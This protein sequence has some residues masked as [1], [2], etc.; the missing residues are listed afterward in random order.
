MTAPAPQPSIADVDAA[1]RSVLRS[2]LAPARG[3]LADGARFAPARDDMFTG[4]LLS[5]REAEAL[6]PGA[7]VVRVAPGT[8]V[9]PLARDH[10]KRQGVEVRFVSRAEVDRARNAGEWGFTIGS[11]T[12]LLEAFRRSILDGPEPWAELGRGLNDATAWVLEGDARGALVLTDDAAPAVYLACQVRGIRAAAAEEPGGVAKAV[13][14]LGVNVLVVESAGKS[15]ALLKQI[16][17][18]FRRAGGPVAP[19]WADGFGRGEGR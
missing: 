11:D 14:T 10:L 5:L 18:T 13:R 7:R 9:T 17:Q 12:G 3:R 2:A 1:V 15:I 19:E 6:P 16:G 8:V 4:R